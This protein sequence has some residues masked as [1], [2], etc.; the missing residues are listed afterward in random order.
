MQKLTF[1]ALA[2]VGLAA[3]ADT[4]NITT[5]ASRTIDDSFGGGQLNWDTGVGIPYRLGVFNDE[6]TYVI[7]AAVQ[8]I[9]RGE[10]RQVVGAMK[11]TANGQALVRSLSWA[12]QYPG[13]GDLNGR[14][15][16][17]RKTLVP[18]QDNA[19]ISV[20]LTKTTFNRQG[21]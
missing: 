16:D 12:P 3:C 21:F 5:V 4:Q 1:A 20:E 9:R 11:V 8:N 14:Q 7:C 15:A 19:R 13:T 6:G 10:D 2:L 18:V 17:C